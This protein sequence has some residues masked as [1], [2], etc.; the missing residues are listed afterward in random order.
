MRYFCIFAGI[1]HILIVG[2][3]LTKFGIFVS[4]LT[5]RPIS[6]ALAII[7]LYL[8]PVSNGSK[9]TME[10][11]VG[12]LLLIFAL[13]PLSFLV[14]FPDQVTDYSL[15]GILDTKGTIFSFLLFI[16]LLE[17][18]RKPAKAWLCQSS[19]SRCS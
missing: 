14:L 16:S 7:F 1:Y 15:Y 3:V 5:H 17:A 4:P 13:I 9:G 19:C 6:L 11:W 18:S 8:M 2:G 12:Y 10:R